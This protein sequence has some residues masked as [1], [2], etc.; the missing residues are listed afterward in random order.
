M[1][2]K[3]LIANRG[4]IAVRVLRACKEMGIPTVAVFSEVDRTALHTR[5]SDEAYCIGPPPARESYLD[6]DKIIDVAIKSGAQ[7]IHP[8]Y[9]FL[10]ENPLFAERC[11]RRSDQAYR[12]FSHTPCGPWAQKRWREKPFRQRASRLFP[13]RW[14]LSQPRRRSLKVALGDRIPR[15]VESHRRRRRQG[16]AFGDQCGGTPIIASNGKIRGEIGL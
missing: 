12:P 11:E 16:I 8:G 1:F 9:G 7:A 3:I 6:I 14:S 2:Q 15:D 4:E 13:G 5:Y 10:A